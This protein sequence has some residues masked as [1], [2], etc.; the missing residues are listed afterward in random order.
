[1][2]VAQLGDVTVNNSRL[3]MWEADRVNKELELG[4]PMQYEDDDQVSLANLT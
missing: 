1:M 4:L 3:I 2:V